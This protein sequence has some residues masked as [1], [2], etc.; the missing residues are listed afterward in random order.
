MVAH[1]EPV[2]SWGHKPCGEICSPT[3]TCVSAGGGPP[4]PPGTGRGKPEVKPLHNSALNSAYGG[5]QIVAGLADRRATNE[6]SS[7]QAAAPA[8]RPIALAPSVEGDHCDWSGGIL[9][10]AFFS[11]LIGDLGIAVK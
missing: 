6:P 2:R 9:R 8:A 11:R 10:E 1:T 7:S 3:T 4:R 5:R